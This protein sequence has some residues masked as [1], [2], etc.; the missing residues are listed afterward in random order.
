M[1][2]DMLKRMLKIKS[3]KDITEKEK[4]EAGDRLSTP[5]RKTNTGNMSQREMLK[6]EL[7]RK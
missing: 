3:D 7:K 4:K 5:E 6:K 1:P 2:L